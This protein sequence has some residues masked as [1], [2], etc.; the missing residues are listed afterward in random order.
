[1]AHLHAAAC[2]IHNT[3]DYLSCGK[4]SQSAVARALNSVIT[5]VLPESAKVLI[6]PQP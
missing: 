2:V 4:E 3:P 1:M 6:G 5:L